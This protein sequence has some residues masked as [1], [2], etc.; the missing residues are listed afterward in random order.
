MLVQ[1]DA[2]I[3]SSKT[4]RGD[5]HFGEYKYAWGPMRLV[6]LALKSPVCLLLGHMSRDDD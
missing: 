4:R 3:E 1:R 6:A 2:R 5:F